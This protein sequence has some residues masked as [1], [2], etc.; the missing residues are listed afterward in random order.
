MSVD[1]SKEFWAG[2]AEF[3]EG[4]FYACHDTLEAIWMEASEPE[5]TFYQGILQIAVACY[6]LGHGNQQGAMILLGEG[7]KRLRPYQDYALP[8]RLSE[9][10]DQSQTLLQELQTLAV[11]EVEPKSPAWQQAV[12]LLNRPTIARQAEFCS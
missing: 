6:H 10:L 4:E 2:V 3:N 12:S 7:M 5:R 8:I 11:S 1:V 9:F